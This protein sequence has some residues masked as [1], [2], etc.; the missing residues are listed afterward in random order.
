MDGYNVQAVVDAKHHLRHV[1]CIAQI[2]PPILLASGFSP[3]LCPPCYLTQLGYH[4]ALKS[5]NSF[6]A[7]L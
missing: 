5:L 7:K 3:H 6:R 1:T 4:K 2:F